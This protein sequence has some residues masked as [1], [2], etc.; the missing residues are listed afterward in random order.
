MLSHP[1]RVSRDAAAELARTD[2][3]LRQSSQDR[4]ALTVGLLEMLPV[5]RRPV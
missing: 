5:V 2:R 1:T 4:I 3:A